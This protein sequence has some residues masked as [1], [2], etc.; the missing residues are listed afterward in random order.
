MI[1]RNIQKTDNLSLIAGVY[2]TSFIETY[3]DFVPDAFLE[4]MN[5]DDWLSS[6]ENHKDF[7]IMIQDQEV[8]GT[9]SISE[10]EDDAGEIQSIY[11]NHD[12]VDQGYGRLLLNAMVKELSERGYDKAFLWDIKENARSK[13]FYE[14]NGFKVTDETRNLNLGGEDFIQVK[15]VLDIESD[16]MIR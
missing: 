16:F 13:A 14:K 4:E 3:R 15:Y 10:G 1:V 12:Y 9:A 7:F 6:V 11:L 5:Q 8:I 2:I